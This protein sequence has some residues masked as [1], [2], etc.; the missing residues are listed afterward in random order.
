[1]AHLIQYEQEEELK[2]E[3]ETNPDAV[4]RNK[5]L[6]R[7]EK[8]EEMG[9]P[10]TKDLIIQLTLVHPSVERSDQANRYGEGLHA[11]FLQPLQVRIFK[12]GSVFQPVTHHPV[13]SDMSYPDEA[14]HGQ[15]SRRKHLPRQQ[16]QQWNGECMGRII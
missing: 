1:M 10:S 9:N 14:D 3:K 13:H 15:P 12:A 8:K 11:I 5:K 7:S 6:I 2:A 4:K 16:E